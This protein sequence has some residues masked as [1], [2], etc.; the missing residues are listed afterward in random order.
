MSD[1]F[2]VV[3][4]GA[5]PAGLTSAYLLASKGY[6]VL[7]VERGE[8]PGSKNMFGGRLYTYELSRIF[9]NFDEAPLEREVK[10]EV[11]HIISKEGKATISL[12]RREVPE[13]SRSFT[14]FRSKFDRWLADRVEEVGAMLITGI[15]VDSLKVEEGKVKGIV[16]GEDVIETKMVI[17]AD[18][19]LSLLAR[20]AGLIEPLNRENFSVGVKEAIRLSE[21]EINE[22]FGVDSSSGVAMIFMGWLPDGLRGEGFLYTMKEHVSVG[23]N[24]R[25]SSLHD[26]AGSPEDIATYQLIEEMKSLVK[27]YID[28]GDLAEYSAHVI[29]ETP[30]RRPYADGLLLVGDAAGLCVNYGLN[31]RGVDL[32][33]RS[34]EAAAEVADEAMKKGDTSS[35]FLSR[36]EEKIS[37]LRR[38]VELLQRISDAVE[39]KP[40]SKIISLLSSIYSA[41]PTEE[42]INHLLKVIEAM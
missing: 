30:V 2:D 22:R 18:G 9:P 10:R 34:G 12:E 24:V 7:V 11:L 41:R 40:L 28:G 17:A 37:D 5:G 38:E 19:V 6:N 16:A 20:R 39:R 27:E 36:Y 25:I 29:P 4:V 1:E 3:V 8:R 13:R 14:V 35:E 21:N 23:L 26:A 31:I 32:A 15:R 42:E 33:V